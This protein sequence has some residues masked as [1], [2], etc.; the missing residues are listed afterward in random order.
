MNTPVK[1]KMR[2]KL[3]VVMAGLMLFQSV[4]P[5]ISYALTSGPAQPEFSS[6]EPVSTNNM[7]NDFTGDFTYNVPV[8]EIPGASGGGYAMSLSY[9][10]GASVEEEASWVGYGW[11]LNPGAINR[12]KR[13]FPDDSKG[14]QVTFWNKTPRNFTVSA[15]PHVGMEIY[16]G[17]VSASF[18]I[19]PNPANAENIHLSI[20]TQ[21]GREVLVV[22]YDATG[23]ESYSK[24]MITGKDGTNFYAIDPSEKLNA[25]L[26]LVTATADQTIYGKR[27]IIK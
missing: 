20:N 16:S 24:V 17:A 25:G 9:H 23:R 26:Y 12:N 7:V 6:F 10:S 8:I 1:N 19:Y 2:K 21:R 4:R 18:N 3:A 14:G 11:T 15:G 13:G 5:T 22:L 27:L